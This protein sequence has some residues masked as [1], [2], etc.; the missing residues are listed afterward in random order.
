MWQVVCGILSLVAICSNGRVVQGQVRD[1]VVGVTPTC[2]EGF[3]TCW[4]G[5]YAGLRTL[6]N[7]QLVSKN[8]DEYNCTVSVRL[9][10]S[11]LPDLESWRQHFLSKNDRQIAVR[12]AEV[13]L[14]GEVRK[15]SD[16]ALVC[17]VPDIDKPLRLAPLQ[18]KLQWNLKK[19][20]ARG[21]EPEEAAAFSSLAKQL[22]ASDASTMR[23]ML[24]GPLQ[25]TKDGVVLEVRE[26]Y[27]LDK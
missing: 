27:P 11:N 4:A 12:G 15:E 8:P 22:G 24:V 14:E 9:K 6:D 1:V 7:V 26:F 23:V 21:P 25:S 10:K 13:T 19:G 2:P 17:N 20:R 5:I 16:K 18:N 3:G